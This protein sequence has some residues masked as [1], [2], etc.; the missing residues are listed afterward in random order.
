[1]RHA[2]RKISLIALCLPLLLAG[3]WDRMEIND[4]AF[5]MAS[6]NDITENGEL[7][8][9]TK[10]A[11]PS[12][13]GS[14][15][16]GGASGVNKS[17]VIESAS[18]RDINDIMQKLQGKLPRRLNISHRRVLYIGEKLAKRGI[19][20]ILDHYSRNPAS[21]HIAY[22]LVTKGSES[23][24]F[25]ESS[26]PL[27]RIPGEEVRELER[28]NTGAV[29]SLRDYLITDNSSGRTPV[30][31]VVEMSGSK[32]REEIMVGG[33]AMFKKEKL[34]G[35][36]S[37][38]ETKVMHLLTNRIKYYRISSNVPKEKGKVAMRLIKGK[39]KIK[40]IVKGDDV[41]F[42]VEVQ[43]IGEVLE[44][45]TKL[46]LSK[47]P[48]LEKVQEALRKEIQKKVQKAV[49]NIQEKYRADVFGFGESIFN[50]EPKV[51]KRLE[52]RW[53]VIFA[54][55]EVTVKTK[56]TLRNAGMNGEPFHI[57][58]EGE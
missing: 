53:E 32:G 7:Q 6:S 55:A 40:P 29:Y 26:N 8:G 1:M 15:R 35:Y 49:A 37:S 56:L 47:P 5:V 43:I 34:I 28:L 20:P 19:A 23:I 48:D 2:Y 11:V 10:I 31:G 42:L 33:S 24:H 57:K 18:G 25:L 36:L 45:N 52:P 58:E 14:S 16:M 12:G 50:K 54:R 38:D 39:C 17:F 41:K 13:L 9:A 4:I 44:N 3:C 22:V 51:W 21:R 46:D 27:E 30:M